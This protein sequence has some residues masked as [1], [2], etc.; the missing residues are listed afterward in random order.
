MFALLFALS[1]MP[2][3]VAAPAPVPNE[4]RAALASQLFDQARSRYVAGSGTLEEVYRWSIR[5]A[6]AVGG[7]AAW[8][9]H[10]ARMVELGGTVASKVQR[11]LAP[12]EELTAAN[13]YVAEA[14]GWL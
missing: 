3:G 14:K 2:Q 11:G 12:V 10:H 7:S 9:A 5:W 13:F 8:T 4:A 6:E 1:S